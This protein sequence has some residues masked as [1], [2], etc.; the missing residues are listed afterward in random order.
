MRETEGALLDVGTPGT[1]VFTKRCVFLLFCLSFSFFSSS[2]SHGRQSLQCPGGVV[3]CVS[4][5]TI[6]MAYEYTRNII[7]RGRAREYA[8]ASTHDS[9]CAAINMRK[10]DLSSRATFGNNHARILIFVSGR[11]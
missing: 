9:R 2:L 1:P 4:R 11:K 6:Y 3:R 10:N 5:L 7:T 8:S